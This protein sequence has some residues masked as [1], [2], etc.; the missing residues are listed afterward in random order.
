MKA[1]DIKHHL[2]CSPFYPEKAAGEEPQAVEEQ[3]LGDGY[4]ALV[5]AD[6]GASV[7][8]LPPLE[9]PYWDDVR[10]ELER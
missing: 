1:S 6:C 3:D 9:D 7:T 8:N 4:K 2:T 5:C 10:G